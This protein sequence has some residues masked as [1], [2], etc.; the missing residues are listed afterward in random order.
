M[1]GGGG[2]G[3]G[4]NPM[5]DIATGIGGIGNAVGGE[6]N[7]VGSGLRHLGDDVQHN[8]G[9]YGGAIVGGP[10][11]AIVGAIGDKLSKRPDQPNAP[12]VDTSTLTA[13]QRAAKDFR[14]SMSNNEE[15]AYSNLSSATN[16]DLGQ[17]LKNVNQSNNARGLLYGGINQGMRAQQRGQ[18][19]YK[20]AQG[21]AQINDAYENAANQMD[22][23]AVNT[24]MMVQQNQ[25]AIQDQIY[26]QALTTMMNR[27]QA[28]GSLLGAGATGVAMMA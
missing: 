5:H 12:G 20:L 9:A 14:D 17:N 11:G 8:Q 22:S 10:G 19:G 4:W 1:G 3:G 21:R 18:A 28:F 27:N 23:A 13:Q 6:S 15:S 25:Q 24:G 16:Q 2:G 7:F 26:Q